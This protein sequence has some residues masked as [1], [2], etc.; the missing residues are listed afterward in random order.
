MKDTWTKRERFELGRYLNNL[1]LM[2]TNWSKDRVSIKPFQESPTPSSDC[3]IVAVKYFDS[4]PEIKYARN[5]T[6]HWFRH[7]FRQTVG[8][9]QGCILSPDLFN[10]F[11]EH[12]MRLALEGNENNEDVKLN[13]RPINN[14][15]FADDIA[16]LSNSLQ[17]MQE[18][19]YRVD[20][21]SSDFGMEISE[22]KTEWMLVRL[23]KEDDRKAIIYRGIQLRESPLAFTKR[24]KYL[25]SHMAEHGESTEDISIRTAIA[26]NAMRELKDI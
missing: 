8:V 13:G 6:T 26:L 10:I 1:Q 19:L 9:R 16:L 18:L 20:K 15:R 22:K 3:L 25:G 4:N 12:V 23:L 2:L 24:F 7:W 21:A 11:L 5:G 14:L 17:R